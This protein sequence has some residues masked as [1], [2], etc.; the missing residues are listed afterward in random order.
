MIITD[1]I[2]EVRKI[3]WAEPTASWGLVPTMGYLHE[4][5]LALVARAKG[6]NRYT[7]VTI[8]VNPTQF[9]P[10]EDLS[11]YP[12]DLQ[13]D[14][15]LLQQAGVDLLFTPNDSVM[16]PPDFQTTVNVT[17]VAQPLEG[18]SRPSHFAGVAVIVAKL[19][20]II[21]PTRAYFGQKDYQQTVVLR[22]MVR[23]LNFN[24]EMLICPTVREADG[25]AMS[26]RNKYLQGA[27][28]TAAL[29]L[30]RALGAVQAE[31]QAGVR[32]ADVLRQRVQSIIGA[33]PLARLDYV[34]VA[35]AT[36][37]QELHDLDEATG[38]VVVS[39]AVFI[40]RTRLI[41]N[42]LL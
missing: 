32:E 21:Q 41:D 28:R 25:L 37:L 23:D 40:G 24:L 35:D 5:H 6:E 42:L 31:A 8:Y 22:Q 33:E 12:R 2:D 18:Q 30:S 17:R 38:G 1:S 29:S 19:F 27:E 9:A 3:R 13:R 14:I 10:S 39:L 15:D 7:A 20:N 11:N 36:S 26:S 16:Y 4:G 34:S